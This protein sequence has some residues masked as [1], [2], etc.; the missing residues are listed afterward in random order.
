MK[1]LHTSDWHLGRALYGRK[2]DDE[3]IAFLDWL[4]KT[5]TEQQIDVLL[6]AGDV[7]DTSTPS[8]A[9]QAL[10]YQFLSSIA[11][12][13]QCQHVVII[14]GN[15]DSPTFLNAP[16]TLLRALNVHVVGAMTDNLA[17]EVLVL[18]DENKMP[19]AIICAVPYLRDKDIRT[20]QAG[21]TIDD[22]NKKLMEGLKAHYAAVCKIA[23]QTQAQIQAQNKINIPIIGMGHLFAAGGK[24]VDQDGVRDLYVGSLA[25]VGID[26]FPSCIDYLALGHLHVPQ[27]VGGQ[28]HIRYCGSPIAMGFGEAKQTKQII[29]VTF[30]GQ[31]KTINSLPIPCFQPLV[32]IVGDI[33]AIKQTIKDLKREQSNA[34]IEVE[35]TGND[36]LPN[37][38]AEIETLI[39]GTALEIRRVKNKQLL[40]RMLDSINVDET[41]DDLDAHDVFQRCLVAHQ[42]ESASCNTLSA[43]YNI[44]LQDLNEAD[45]NAT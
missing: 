24:T 28:S 37:L 30:D 22:K 17:D 36:V 12:T 21:E 34:W 44:I 9:A 7:F 41:L 42:V 45:S 20:A 11:A 13:S 4:K 33:N 32:R 10:Y 26:A 1:L 27:I 8:N 39:E 31:S 43:L 25:H 40:T 29:T 3:F 6:I 19:Q 14:A 16:Q 35:Y 23:E 15:H 18:H 5:I 38:K 2:R